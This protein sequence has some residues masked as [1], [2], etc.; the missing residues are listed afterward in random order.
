MKQF[1]KTFVSVYVL[2]LAA[3]A[4]GCSGGSGTTPSLTPQGERQ[5]LQSTQFQ[6]IERL[7][8][9]AIKEAT[10]MFAQH[11]DT[12][13]VSPV[14]EP[15]SSQ[16]LFQSIGTFVTQAAGRRSDYATTLQAVLIPD[17]MAVDLSQNTTKAAYLGVETKGATGSAYGGRALTDDVITTDLSAIFGTALSDLG[18]VPADGKQSPCLAT[19]NV[20]VDAAAKHLT[21]TFPFVGSPN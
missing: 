2:L 16:S 15:L 17:E 8:R 7:A 5:R 1:V 18:L 12:N 19:D 10:Q 14:Q 4:S 6:Q 9:P 11:E 21:T 13:R 3:S 20:P